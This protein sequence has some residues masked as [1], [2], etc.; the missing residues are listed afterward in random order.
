MAKISV[1]VL[2]I[3]A[4]VSTQD[5]CNRSNTFPHKESQNKTQLILGYI[6]ERIHDD[7]TFDLTEK[8]TVQGAVHWGSR[9][10]KRKAILAH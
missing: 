2:L 3:I 6:R 7:G 8:P 1:K 9:I 10:L 5:A 4:R